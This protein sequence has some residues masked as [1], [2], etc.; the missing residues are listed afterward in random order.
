MP[1]RASSKLH[2]GW[3]VAVGLLMAAAIAGGYWLWG[4]VNDPYRT[5]QPLD[6]LAYLENANSLRGNTYRV[7]GT[8]WNSLG[9]SPA[10]GRLFSVEVGAGK[11]GDLLPLLVP[12]SLNHVCLLYTS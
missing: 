9:W 3:L 2:P 7:T 4:K 5:I 1:R 10:A 6:V 8:V 12:A 11:P